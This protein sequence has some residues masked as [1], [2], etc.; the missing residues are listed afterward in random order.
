MR[1][2]A[3]G[4][5][6]DPGVANRAPERA[7]NRHAA[8]FIEQQVLGSNPSVGSSDL[9]VKRAPLAPVSSYH[10]PEVKSLRGRPA[11]ELTPAF[12]MSSRSGSP[13]RHRGRCASGVG[14]QFQEP[15][16]A[17]IRASLFRAS[18][19]RPDSSVKMA[20]YVQFELKGGSR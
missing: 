18:L 20:E 9:N 8:P 17:W 19:F 11:P 13:P 16:K 12:G 3:G 5:G 10:E 6:A 14:P 2:R 15:S 4:K 7:V 1:I